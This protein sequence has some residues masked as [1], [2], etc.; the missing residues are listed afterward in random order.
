[1][2]ECRNKVERLR[3]QSLGFPH[4][5]TSLSLDIRRPMVTPKQGHLKRVSTFV[6]SLPWVISLSQSLQPWHLGCFFPR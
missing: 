4:K 6:L 2:I 3:S 1:M 5:P